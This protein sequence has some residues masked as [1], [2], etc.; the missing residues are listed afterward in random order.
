MNKNAI[1]SYAVWARTELMKQVSQKAYEYGVTENSLPELNTDTINDRLLSS[2]EKSQLNELVNEVRK[3]GFEHVI[4]E[5]AYTWF[6][7]F[8]ALR[9]MEVNN[10]LPR[11]LRVR[12]FTN[13]NN[14]FKPEILSEA[15][16][17][18]M[19]GLDTQKVF[20]YIEKNEQEKLYKY[21]LLTLC[22][23]MNEYLPYMFTSINDYK[24]LLFPDNLL[25]NDSALARLISDI[26]EDSWLDQVQIIGWLYQY[27]N[28]ELKDIVM[29]KKNY[30]KDDIPAATQLFTPDW[31]VR[32]MVENSLGR[33]YINKKKHEGIFADGK[34]LS[35][36]TVD[37][38]NEKRITNEKYIS[39]EMGWKYYLPEAKQDAEVLKELEKIELEHSKLQPEDIK[40]IDPCMG[41]G[42][43]LVYA[44]DVLM[45]IY[46]DA[47][48]SDCDA[49]KSILENNLYGLEIDERAYHLAYFALMMK[50]RQYNRRILSK[51]TNINL[52][53]IVES[54]SELNE[55]LLWRLGEYKELGQYLVDTFKEAKEFGS[56]LNLDCT[57]EQ[58]NELDNTLIEIDKM[59]DYGT[60]LDQIES[61][62]LIDLIDPLLK[63]AKLLVQ[64]YDVVVTNPPYMPPSPKQ[65]PYVQKNY[66][67]SKSDLFA[68][69]IEKCHDLTKKNAYQAM[70]TMHS[71]MFISSFEKLRNKLLINNTIINMAHLGTRAFEDIGGEVVQ[72]T[73]FIYGNKDIKNYQSNFK[74][75]VKYNSQDL[76]E[77]E[78]LKDA[79]LFASSALNFSKIPGSPI[80]YWIN[81]SAINAFNNEN[82][83]KNIGTAKVGIG[84][85]NTD[86]FL[87]IW[88]EVDSN[89]IDLEQ[90]SDAGKYWIPINKGG[91][92]RKWF[93]NNDYIINWKD[94]GLAIK[95]Y[96]DI[97]GK[98]LSYPRN[99]RFQGKESLTWSDISSGA[100]SMRYSKDGYF[101]SDV[102]NSLFLNNPQFKFYV[103]ANC[104][105]KP[106]SLL[107]SIINPTIH[108]KPGNMENM[109]CLMRSDLILNVSEIACK[110]VTNTKQ[111]WDSFE[112]SWDFKVHPLVRLSSC[113]WDATGVG[114]SIMNYYGRYVESSCPLETCFLLWQGECNERFNQ[115]K[116]NEEE[117][118]R[119]FID[120]YGLQD[121]LTPEVEDK[122][123]TVRKADL[124]RDVKSFISYAVGC[125]FGRYSLDVEGLAYAGGEW[126]S[127]K[128]STFIPDADDI[129]PICDDEY[130]VED[131]IVK[132]FIEFVKVVYGS[133]TLEEN[134]KFIADALGG[135]G[136]PKD[137][138][139]NYFL[140]DF[141]KDHCN[142]YQVT[143]SG[144]RPI[145]WL[146]DSG[147]K[148]GFK[149]LVYI[150]RYTPDLVARMRTGYVHPQQARYRDRIKFLQEQ[151]DMAG[152]TS[153]KVKLSKELKKINEQLLELNKY[154][155]IVHHWADKMEPMDLD[156]GVKVNYAKFQELLAKIK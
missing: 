76:K 78:Y 126:D 11:D 45:D 32:Y 65:K 7:R 86:L 23:E 79:N 43:I 71:W 49:S 114:A 18:E 130:Y 39:N 26:D 135:K 111:D 88:F 127:S 22:N 101:F 107:N 156:D 67:D 55:D 117:L 150:H 85:G 64:K 141:F 20:D 91:P 155:E 89:K 136:N 153:E 24:T 59:A 63:Q 139:R 125:M 68:V 138:L 28:S 8:I 29:K 41:S 16:H 77:E 99:L 109:P 33:L 51:D 73:A 52:V 142:T 19:N 84:T 134:L 129:I 97:Y 44:F 53:E 56:I 37:E 13:E 5:V 122:D 118:N 103:I 50:A 12:V 74:R 38:I 21:L 75:L 143:G 119:I 31:I 70:I 87:K 61:Q 94:D 140:N 54:S 132:R 108:F 149:A 145:Y 10:Y 62:Q 4:E 96:T 80:A 42:H 146:F 121:E 82:R 48:Y 147:K 115:L 148:N 17:L 27:Y 92:Y 154:E 9:Y 34:D 14:E 6:N 30:T 47:G 133:D 98:Q 15:L 131:D 144:K 2:D 58:L 137:V 152:S 151:I 104:N 93:G 105:S 57:L 46:R 102:G 72:T 66:P 106:F 1:K 60:L 3:N 120:I 112:T 123:V 113:L 124:V 25:K 95:N 110:C 83:I 100:F 36:M 90:K 128:Y 81:K 40:L 35:E 69:F 116:A